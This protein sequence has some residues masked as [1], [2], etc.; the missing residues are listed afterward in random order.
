[1]FSRAPRFVRNILRFV[2]FTK[3]EVDEIKV[4]MNKTTNSHNADILHAIIAR[5]NEAILIT[6]DRHFEEL[7]WI[8][9]VQKPEEVIF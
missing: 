1:M 7:T 2:E 5:D 9:S 3:E 4:I 8:V 6:R